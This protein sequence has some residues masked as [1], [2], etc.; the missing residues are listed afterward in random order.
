M[1]IY[2]TLHVRNYLCILALQSVDGIEI[3]CFCILSPF[4]SAQIDR[5][6]SLCDEFFQLDC[7]VK[8]NYVRPASGSGHGWVAFEREK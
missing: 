3:I 5:I 8:Q 7:A 4:A 6:F 1:L 2:L